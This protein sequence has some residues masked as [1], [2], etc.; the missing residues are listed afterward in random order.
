MKNLRIFGKTNAFPVTQTMFLM[1]AAKLDSDDTLCKLSSHERSRICAIIFD[2]NYFKGDPTP[3]HNLVCAKNPLTFLTENGEN[4][5]N[6]EQYHKWM[7]SCYKTSTYYNINPLSAHYLSYAYEKDN[8]NDNDKASNS[9]YI[10]TYIRSIKSPN[11]S[12][13]GVYND[14]RFEN[15]FS[16]K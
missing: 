1:I 5:A 9:H 16:R 3:L 7:I 13:T 6:G 10:F 15:I 12:L 11:I 8:E 2:F 4:A 14:V